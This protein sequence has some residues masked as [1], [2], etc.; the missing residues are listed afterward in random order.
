MRNVIIYN[1]NR[2]HN[3]NI[4]PLLLSYL[5]ANVHDKVNVHMELKDLIILVKMISIQQK[6]YIADKH[7]ISHKRCSMAI[8]TL[9]LFF[10][11]NI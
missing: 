11:P 4:K 2:F 5:Y 3:C 7:F 1:N 8:I 9:Q 6:I 10:F